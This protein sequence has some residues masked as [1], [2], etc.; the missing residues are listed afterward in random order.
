MENF[1][2]IPCAL[3]GRGQNVRVKNKSH[4]EQGETK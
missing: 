4:E 2:R 1:W 3:P